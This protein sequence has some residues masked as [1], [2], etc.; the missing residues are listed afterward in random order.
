MKT[1]A[2]ICDVIPV[3]IKLY[4]SGVGFAFMNVSLGS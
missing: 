2:L 1:E 4:V 3:L